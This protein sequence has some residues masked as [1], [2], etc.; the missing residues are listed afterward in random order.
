M[1][2]LIFGALKPLL[3]VLAEVLANVMLKW[4][5]TP[6]ETTTVS[7]APVPLDLE[8]VVGPLSADDLLRTYGGM[9]EDES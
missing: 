5:S 9:L 6:D 2:G 1:I 4:G 7:D 8:K 3:E